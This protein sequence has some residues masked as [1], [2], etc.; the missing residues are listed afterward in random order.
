MI[1][2]IICE[3]LIF[4]DDFEDD[5]SCY[6]EDCHRICHKPLVQMSFQSMF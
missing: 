3:F 5:L 2:M 4:E 6:F 1:R